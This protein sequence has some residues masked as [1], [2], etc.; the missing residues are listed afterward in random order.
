MLPVTL[1]GSATMRITPQRACYKCGASLAGQSAK[2][3]ILTDPT[4]I[5]V[6]PRGQPTGNNVAPQ[7]RFP[8]PGN[9]TTT[10]WSFDVYA[11]D[12]LGE[13]AYGVGGPTWQ[14]FQPLYGMHTV[15]PATITATLGTQTQALPAA[16]NSIASPS[17]GTPDAVTGT[18]S[19]HNGIPM[20]TSGAPGMMSVT[21]TGTSSDVP[22][23]LTMGAMTGVSLF[24]KSSTINLRN[25]MQ[26]ERLAAEAGHSCLGIVGPSGACMFRA[27]AVYDRG[28]GAYEVATGYQG[29]ISAAVSCAQAGCTAAIASSS[30]TYG[31]ATFTATYTTSG[32]AQCNCS[33]SI[34]ANGPYRKESQKTGRECVQNNSAA[35]GREI[36]KSR[37]G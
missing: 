34:T 27:M 8:A 26:A 24:G 33:V 1:Q 9:T 37:N 12:D 2:F 19:V 16:Q 32:T 3:T 4:H 31:V 13:R 22:V 6:L 14:A 7:W 5:V 35:G 23:T 11:A 17:V 15:A 25:S 21:V 30:M 20:P 36:T 28:G 10:A 29:K 18:Y